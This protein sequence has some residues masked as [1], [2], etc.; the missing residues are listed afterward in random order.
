MDSLTDTEVEPPKP[1]PKYKTPEYYREYYHNKVKHVFE[2][3]FCGS[4]VVGN[5]SK[6]MRH[7]NTKKCR[8]FAQRRK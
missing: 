4:S 2:C 7:T 3:P 8:Q 5:E 1:T 6:F